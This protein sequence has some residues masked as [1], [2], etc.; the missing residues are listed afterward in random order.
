MGVGLEG[1]G[2]PGVGLAHHGAMQVT[3]RHWTRMEGKLG[4]QLSINPSN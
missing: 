2:Q 1:S 3:S 4:K